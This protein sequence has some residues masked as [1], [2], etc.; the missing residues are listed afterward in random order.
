[1]E[2]SER[3]WDSSTVHTLFIH[4]SSIHL[5]LSPPTLLSPSSPL[6]HINFYAESYCIFLSC[7]FTLLS[8]PHFTLLPLL[9]SLHSP[10]LSSLHSPPS[11]LLTS[12]S[13]PLIF[14]SPPSFSSL[15]FSPLLTSY[16][17]F[18]TTLYTLCYRTQ[19]SFSSPIATHVSVSPPS[20]SPM[21]MSGSV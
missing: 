12:L 10:L 18:C 16:L 13:S 19:I 15:L 3:C 14:S 4:S 17:L 5:S 2:S 6:R 8:S 11:P 20:C 9:S 21:T 1:M 7:H